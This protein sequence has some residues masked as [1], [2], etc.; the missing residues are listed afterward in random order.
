MESDLTLPFVFVPDGRPSPQGWW[1]AQ[2]VA[3][4]AQFQPPAGVPS[5][6]LLDPN[7][8]QVLD[9]KGQ[10]V[11]RPADM[12]P[13]LFVQ[14]GERL[15]YLP[16][17]AMV[18]RL[19]ADLWKFRQ[20]GPWD[21]QRRDGRNIDEWVDYATIAIGLYA[22]AA[23]MSENAILIMQNEYAR[24]NSNFGKVP[25][26]ETYAFLPKRNVF[27]TKLGFDLYR[28]GLGSAEPWNR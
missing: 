4:P 14:Q 25:M 1:P 6:P 16:P 27:N 7:D 17:E 2:P 10:P 13:E 5:V 23:G 9:Y 28:S 22:A 20:S 3:V 8:R 21:A 26:D 24:R 11:R 19:G 12:P 18:A 15:R